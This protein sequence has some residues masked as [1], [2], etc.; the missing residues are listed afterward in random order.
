MNFYKVLG[1]H[2]REAIALEF[3]SCGWDRLPATLTAPLELLWAFCARVS[4]LSHLCLFSFQFE[5]QEHSGL[6]G[7]MRKSELRKERA[8]VRQSGEGLED[9]NKITEMR[10]WHPDLWED[11]GGVT[12]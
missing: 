5:L 12:K 2:L 10:V 11:E 6:L 1:R 4:G 7:I 3:C 9:T 8:A